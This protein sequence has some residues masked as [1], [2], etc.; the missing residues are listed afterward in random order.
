MA[1]AYATLA[2]HGV[3][4]A[5]YG[6]ERITDA[7]GRLLFQARPQPDQAVRPPIAAIVDD[8]LTSVIDHGTGVRAAIGR[9]AAGKTGTTERNADAWF[10]GFTPQLS[11]AVWTG[12][13]EG[14][15]PMHP[16]R[17]RITVLGGTY[18]AEIWAAFMRAALA[19]QPVADFP[20]PATDLVTVV[21]DVT[22]D[23]L[24]NRF[25]P[26]SDVGPVVYLRSEAPTEV[27]KEPS[28]PVS[29]VVAAVV[30]LP[31]ATASAYL[32]AAGFGVVQ[33]L[34]AT[35]RAAP[36]TVLAQSPLGGL[37]PQRGSA[38]IITVAAD[39][40]GAGGIGV[41]LVPDVLGQPGQA[42]RALLLL[43]GLSALLTEGCEAG[44]PGVAPGSVWKAAP[45][46]GET[47]RSGQQVQ[48][49]VSPA[50]PSACL[51]PPPP[52]TRPP[53]TSAST[54]TTTTATTTSRT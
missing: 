19:G 34:R 17:S 9:P 32:A 31:V 36:G 52:T 20:S 5:P 37:T 38:V 44:G 51:P 40:N 28:E 47:V 14:E 15:V 26:S 8:V 4:A 16:P 7:S 10:V 49:W 22:R 18:P 50:E 21:V 48:I 46:P 13:P 2:G 3:H 35:D 30:G 53:P 45:A 54:T 33:R 6:V 12:Y 24:R 25:T 43:A 27:C 41:T 29:G 1:D 39:A 11:T 42:A 23:C